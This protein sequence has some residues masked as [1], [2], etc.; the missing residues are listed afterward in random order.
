VWRDVQIFRGDAIGTFI[1]MITFRSLK[2]N[3]VDPERD[4]KAT[5]LKELKTKIPSPKG[6]ESLFFSIPHRL[7]VILLRRGLLGHYTNIEEL[8]HGQNHEITVSVAWREREAR[9]RLIPYRLSQNTRGVARIPRAH[10]L[11]LHSSSFGYRP[12]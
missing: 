12:S 8:L 3:I 7:L 11:H 9:L 5:P 1:A 10:Q 6:N 2:T 4:T